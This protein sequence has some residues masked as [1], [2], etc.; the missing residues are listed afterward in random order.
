MFDLQNETYRDSRIHTFR[1]NANESVVSPALA[2]FPQAA[3]AVIEG[4]IESLTS[5]L[6]KHPNLTACRSKKHGA[7]LLHY[8]A[9]NSPVED[10]MQ[11]CPS[12]AVEVAKLLLSKGC[13]VDATIQ[14]SGTESRSTPLVALVTSE[15]LAI[16]GLQCLLVN[17]FLDYGANV[18]GLD[19]DGYPLAC[20][21]CF[22]YMDA[23]RAL[24][25]RCARVD[26]V[27]FGAALGN[28]DAVQDAF[29]RDRQL[30]ALQTRLYPD[31]FESR[32]RTDEEMVSLALDYSRREGHTEI[33]AF[34][35]STLCRVAPTTAS[36]STKIATI[37]ATTAT[38]T[39]PTTTT[40]TSTSTTTTPTTVQQTSKSGQGVK[41][42]ELL[43]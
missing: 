10:D 2:H 35:N 30:K 24:V 41:N 26:N 22:G 5:L 14:G 12:N 42:T 16:S 11:K 1:G 25:V 19:D 8:V 29:G 13:E 4:D 6:A 39:T 27:V 43:S 18:N 33:E 32:Q 23:A 34:L 17:V 15:F 31:P 38:T 7:S 20:A 36:T 9:A 3:R 21:L 37:I 40:T 28:F